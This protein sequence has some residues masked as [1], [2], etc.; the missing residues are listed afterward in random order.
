MVRGMYTNRSVPGVDREV[1]QIYMNSKAGRCVGGDYELD[2]WA[3]VFCVPGLLTTGV[4]LIYV[5]GML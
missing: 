2:V 4:I 3:P 1:L 5:Q